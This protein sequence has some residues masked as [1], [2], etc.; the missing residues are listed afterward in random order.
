L[1]VQ[2]AVELCWIVGNLKEMFVSFAPSPFSG[3][4]EG[5]NMTQGNFT[6]ERL[7][8]IGLT[9]AAFDGKLDTCW[10]CVG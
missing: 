8:D 9:K 1:V 6:G 2:D 10:G 4:E 5:K 3:V 7:V